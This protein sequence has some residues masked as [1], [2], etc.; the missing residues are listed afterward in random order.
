MASTVAVA[1]WL[2]REAIADLRLGRKRECFGFDFHEDAAERADA[3]VKCRRPGVLEVRK[4]APDPWLKMVFEDGPVGAAGSNDLAAGE[5][6]HDFE[7]YRN[8]I[9]GFRL[10]LSPLKADLLQGFAD[11][12]ER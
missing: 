3:F 6:G 7:K 9:L 5:A 8:V 11:P 10:S 12:G 1:A 2:C 4:K